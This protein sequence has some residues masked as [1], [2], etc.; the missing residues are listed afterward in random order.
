MHVRV[1]IANRGIFHLGIFS[2]P[3]FSGMVPFF[4][5]ISRRNPCIDPMKSN[6]NPIDC[7]INSV[8][9]RKRILF[10]VDAKINFHVGLNNPPIATKLPPMYHRSASVFFSF[11]V[12]NFANKNAPH[13]KNRFGT[14]SKSAK[15]IAYSSVIQK[16]LITLLKNME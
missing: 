7:H 10:P 3:S 13:R 11:L 2:I 6:V 14:K 8:S 9:V 15:P 5:E 12:K 16:C 1:W 4:L